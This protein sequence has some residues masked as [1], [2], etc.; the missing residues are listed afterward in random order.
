MR[1]RPATL[2]KGD[3]MSDAYIGKGAR[4]AIRNENGNAP[5]LGAVDW[6][7]FAAAPTFAIIALLTCVGGGPADI[8]CAAVRDASPLSGMAPMYVL[9]SVFHA[10]PWLKLITGRRSG[11]GRS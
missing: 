11:T 8:L 2:Q 1:G 6:L 5:A 3:I 9:M 10:A 7:G 4:G